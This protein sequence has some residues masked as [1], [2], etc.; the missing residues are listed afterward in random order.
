[1]NQN[2]NIKTITITNYSPFFNFS[3]YSLI[4]KKVIAKIGK[5]WKTEWGLTQWQE[6]FCYIYTT[7][8][9]EVFGNW[10]YSYSLAMGIDLSDK[11]KYNI[12]SVE[13]SKL[14]R[15]PKIIGRINELL[16]EWWLNDQNVDKQ[17]S[18][19]VAQFDDKSSK[20][21]AIKEYNRLK[22]RVIEKWSDI[23]IDFNLEGKSIKQLEELRKQI[24]QS[25][26][27]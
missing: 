15:N 26:T 10:T 12:C 11:K 20:L 21:A 25:K 13:A 4:M 1:M 14:L 27:K 17:L 18:F 5:G 9:R 24:L 16:E 2:L 3:N 19:L 23:H 8:D 22:A 6:A 7:S